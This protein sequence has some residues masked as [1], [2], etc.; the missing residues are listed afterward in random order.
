[1]RELVIQLAVTFIVWS[2]AVELAGWAMQ[3][4][5]GERWWQKLLEQRPPS[6]KLAE[7]TRPDASIS[8]RPTS[9]D[10]P[11]LSRRSR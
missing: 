1:M 2:V 9:G 8:Y 10:L 7:A 11:R 3:R 6:P 5:L 4:W